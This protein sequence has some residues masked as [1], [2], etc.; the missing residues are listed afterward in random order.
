LL[1]RYI[2]EETPHRYF[3]YTSK[4]QRIVLSAFKVRG[5]RNVEAHLFDVFWSLCFL[6]D[7]K[8]KILVRRFELFEK[9]YL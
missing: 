3:D 9:I 5:H 2:V 4:Q 7:G 1:R 6:N 8:Q